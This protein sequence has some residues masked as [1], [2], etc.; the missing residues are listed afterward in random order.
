M[1]NQPEEVAHRFAQGYVGD[2]VMSAIQCC[3]RAI[4]QCHGRDQQPEGFR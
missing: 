3:P 4:G 2:V 1:K